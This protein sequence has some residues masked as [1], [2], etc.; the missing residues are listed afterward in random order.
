MKEIAL[1]E[2]DIMQEITLDD[3]CEIVPLVDLA[4]MAQVNNTIPDLPTIVEKETKTVAGKKA[5]IITEYI[6]G[7][8]QKSLYID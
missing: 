4:Q 1:L 7:A 2:S 3:D 5:E 8:N 6:G